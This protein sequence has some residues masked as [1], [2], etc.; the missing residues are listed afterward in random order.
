MEETIENALMALESAGM[1]HMLVKDMQNGFMIV[2]FDT[3]IKKSHYKD[4]ESWQYAFVNK[5]KG[6]YKIRFDSFDDLIDTLFNAKEICYGAYPRDAQPNP[7][8]GKSI[9]QL[10]IEKDLNNDK[11]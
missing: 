5:D 3:I 4:Y 7:L 9:E 11:N 8:Y 6:M 1:P 10:K 2:P